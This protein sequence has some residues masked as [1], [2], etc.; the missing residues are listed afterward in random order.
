MTNGKYHVNILYDCID[1]CMY[2]LY[3]RSA[4]KTDDDVVDIVVALDSQRSLDVWKK[5]QLLK[6]TYIYIY[7]HIHIHI[8]IQTY[9]HHILYTRWATSCKLLDNMLSPLSTADTFTRSIPLLTSDIL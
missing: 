5:V 3:G 2:V 6:H 9:I 8:H 1:M 4:A 7:I